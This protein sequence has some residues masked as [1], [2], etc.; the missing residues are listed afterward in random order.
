MKTKHLF[1]LVAVVAVTGLASS[2]QAGVSIKLVLGLPVP[3]ITA[4]RAVVVVQPPCPPPAPVVV[5]KPV[6]R[7][8]PVVVYRPV[9]PCRPVVYVAPRY[10]R[11][12]DYRDQRGYDHRRNNGREERGGHGRDD[13]GQERGGRR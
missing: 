13:R 7:C 10:D 3:V 4:P 5:C 11:Y 9:A 8:E 2:T 12:D 6:P 1:G